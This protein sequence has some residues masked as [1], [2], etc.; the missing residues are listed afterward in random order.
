MYEGGIR[1]PFLM[2]WPGKLPA[3]K[4][5]RRPVISLDLFAISANLAKAPLPRYIQFDG[6]DLMPYLTGAN[7][8]R[9]HRQLYWRQQ[10]RTALR[11][12]DWKLVRNPGRGAGAD[13][14]LYNLGNDIGESNDLAAQQPERLQDMIRQWQQF[15]EQMI[16]PFWSPR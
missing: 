6:V 8:E 10:Q 5:E 9:P 7:Q 3:G 2:Q 15:D 12:E 11:V 4:V 16:E 14:Q 13:W 1:V